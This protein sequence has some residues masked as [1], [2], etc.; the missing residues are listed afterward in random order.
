MLLVVLI[1]ISLWR[2]YKHGSCRRPRYRVAKGH[3]G[4]VCRRHAR[5]P[6][7]PVPPPPLVAPHG[8]QTHS[9]AGMKDLVPILSYFL[10][11]TKFCNT[12]N[13]CIISIYRYEWTSWIRSDHFVSQDA[14]DYVCQI[15][16][17]GEALE[18]AHTVEVMGK[19]SIIPYLNTS[20]S[21]MYLL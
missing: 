9:A 18:V 21:Y 5:L 7:P 6:R 20:P 14:G 8:A 19:L 17:L 10:G 11:C 3:G 13:S 4:L 16:I 1:S 2:N 12:Q 15:S